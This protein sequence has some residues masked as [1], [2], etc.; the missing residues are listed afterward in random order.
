VLATQVSQSAEALRALVATTATTVAASQQ[1]LANTLTARITTLEQAQYEGKGKA[2]Y[3]D[4]Q[5]AELA[6]EVK[7]LR[8]SR[9]N[10]RGQ[11]T[12]SAAVIAYMIA[13]I[14]AL[15]ALA[16]LAFSALRF[17]RRPLT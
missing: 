6:T 10:V 16:S 17:N 13:A 7:Q 1:Q 8:E 3:I 5:I 4:P 12:G 2:G 14:M 9:D 11:D 15:L